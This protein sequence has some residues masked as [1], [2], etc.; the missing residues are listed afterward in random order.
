MSK[1]KENLKILK[2]MTAFLL[3]A[4]SII[5]MFYNN[6]LFISAKKERSN[7]N[8]K[9]NFNGIASNISDLSSRSNDYLADKVVNAVDNGQ[10]YYILLNFKYVHTLIYYDTHTEVIY[11]HGS[12]YAYTNK[13]TPANP[14][15][16]IL[17]D[18]RTNPGPTPVPYG[19]GSI[20]VE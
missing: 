14:P 6:N 18:Y 17:I 5:T 2:K 8:G 19:G 15:Q 10:L 20:Y 4:I 9:K 13:V 3:I 7:V 11:E 12:F 16:P 1:S